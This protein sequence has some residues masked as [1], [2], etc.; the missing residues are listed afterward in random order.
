MVASRVEDCMY[1]RCRDHLELN[2]KLSSSSLAC[3]LLV[4]TKPSESFGIIPPSTK[5]RRRLRARPLLTT[6]VQSSNTDAFDFSSK[7]GWDQ[8]Y[9]KRSVSS[10]NQ[11]FEPYEWH[12]SMKHDEIFSSTLPTSCIDGS[13][14]VVGCGNSLLPI[15]L[16]NYHKGQSHIICLDYSSSCINQLVESW[17]S[18]SNMSFVVGDATRLENIPDVAKF[19]GKI[20][21]I[22]D[23]GLIDALMCGEGWNGDVERLLTSAAR[24]LKRGGTY[25]CVSY[26][27]S[28]ATKEFLLDVGRNVGFEWEFDLE[29]E[30]NTRVSLSKAVKIRIYM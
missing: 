18:R 13:I 28:A 7:S 30:N 19:E 9:E 29:D 17:G 5:A 14:L 12:S 21:A 22:V 8:F 4:R 16:D 25:V 24:Q 1:V 27:L 11:T 26:K 23:K 10:D 2:M 20:G 3:L 6:V 15:D